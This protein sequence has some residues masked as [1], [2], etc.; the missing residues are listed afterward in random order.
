MHGKKIRHE[1]VQQNSEIFYIL[2]FY[3]VHIFVDRQ[4]MESN[5]S[6]FSASL[7]ISEVN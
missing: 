2:T 5:L 3:T 4:C 1:M 6:F 7:I